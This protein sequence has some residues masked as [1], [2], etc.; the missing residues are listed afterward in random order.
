MYPER[1]KIF[2]LESFNRP[3]TQK[4]AEGRF[5]YSSSM[6]KDIDVSLIPGRN[7][8]TQY[9]CYLNG[10]H[11]LERYPARAGHNC[12]EEAFA[13]E[14]LIFESF[15]GNDVH[16]TGAV[17]HREI[18]GIDRDLFAGSQFF[19]DDR[20]VDFEEGRAVSGQLL[21]DKALAAK[22]A[23]SKFLLEE[24]GKFHSRSRCQERGLLTDDLLS[25]ADLHSDDVSRKTRS[26]RDRA[27]LPLRGVTVL[28]H[29]LAGQRL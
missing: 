11:R 20:A 29:I 24:D 18:S 12:I 10:R 7:E 13:A 14:K 15:Y 22:K 25:R 16:R 27:R 23:G 19:R 8:W 21:H 2:E 28:E 9:T 26:E 5:F 4:R 17:H 6:S 3:E 1:E